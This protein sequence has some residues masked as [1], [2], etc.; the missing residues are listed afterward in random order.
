MHTGGG[1]L[2]GLGSELGEGE[3]FSG[4]GLGNG[5]AGTGVGLVG[6]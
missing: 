6:D 2:A 1:E 4:L 5:D 3:A